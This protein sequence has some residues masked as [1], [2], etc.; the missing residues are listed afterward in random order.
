MG[1]Y[2]SCFWKK[3]IA[4]SDIK[5][6]AEKKAEIIDSQ[7]V[8]N[9]P[10]NI[11]DII[12]GQTLEPL[13]K[14]ELFSKWNTYRIADI[15]CGSGNFLLSAYEYILNC[16]TMYYIE[17]DKDNALQRGIL[18]SKGEGSYTLSF[19]KKYQILKQNIYGVDIDNLATEV[20]KF[21]LLIK[22]IEDVSL[23]EIKNYAV[24]T[25]GKVLP[26]LD[27]NIS[28]WEQPGGFQIFDL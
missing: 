25:H 7:G 20:A 5:V 18:V 21:S 27:N 28:K 16:Y 4:I 9:T 1:R 17:M 26:N 19:D 22:L 6:V 14:Y 15:C 8:V 10:K 13:Y 2:T 23:D 12:V 3:K 24:S 11:T